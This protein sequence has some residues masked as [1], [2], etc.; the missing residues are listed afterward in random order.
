MRD[1][2]LAFYIDADHRVINY[3]EDKATQIVF[4]WK[5][6]YWNS[7]DNITVARSDVIFLAN[8]KDKIL[9][10]SKNILILC[11]NII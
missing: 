8:L 6:H 9:H 7:K 1:P 3:I 5:Y 10:K 4:D 2:D 11:K